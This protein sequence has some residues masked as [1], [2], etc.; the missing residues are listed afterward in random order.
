MYQL[1]HSFRSFKTILQTWSDM[2]SEPDYRPKISPGTLQQICNLDNLSEVS[3]FL[4]QELFQL[5]LPVKEDQ[6]RVC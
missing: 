4:F 2:S 5:A 3:K 6:F 1:L